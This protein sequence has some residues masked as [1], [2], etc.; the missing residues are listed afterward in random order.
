MKGGLTAGAAVL[1]FVI[2]TLVVRAIASL[3]GSPPFTGS[4]A[5]ED[6]SRFAARLLASPAPIVALALIGI[7]VLAN[8]ASFEEA[9]V[10]LLMTSAAMA[11]VLQ[12]LC[13]ELL[14]WS[15]HP[16]R[17]SGEREQRIVDRLRR[18]GSMV[19]EIWVSPTPI[20]VFWRLSLVT[21]A[22][23]SR[24]RLMLWESAERLPAE[25]AGGLALAAPVSR[26]W[27]WALAPFAAAVGLRLRDPLSLIP[28]WLFA[29]VGGFIA[30]TAIP[31]LVHTIRIERALRTDAGTIDA[32]RG[33]LEFG[34]EE[35]RLCM[36]R[37][38]GIMARWSAATAWARAHAIARRAA[39]RARLPEQIVD[40]EVAQVL[41]GRPVAATSR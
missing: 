34:R 13:S 19:N 2:G 14:L 33:A 35:A 3:A 1:V 17:M 40:L 5:E 38:E 22:V 7:A 27:P 24:S 36:G 18:S 15:H 12:L 8:S 16:V 11:I 32:I 31:D 25:D 9:I 30:L 28:W 23:L 20:V 21:P 26:F 29:A 37:G 39:R 4:S 41:H 6:E 10:G